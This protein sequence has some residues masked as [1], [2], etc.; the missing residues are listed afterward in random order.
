MQ[1]TAFNMCGFIQPSFIVEMLESSDP[2][3]FNDRQLFVYPEE[4]YNANIP[5]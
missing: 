3:A 4:V 1:V 5:R 2:D